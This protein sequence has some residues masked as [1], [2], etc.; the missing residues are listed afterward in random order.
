[1]IGVTHQIDYKEVCIL[2]GMIDRFLIL[3]FSKYNFAGYKMIY[4]FAPS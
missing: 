4:N 2:L 1:M 3:K